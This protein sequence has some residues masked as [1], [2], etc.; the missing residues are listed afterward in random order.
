MNLGSQTADSQLSRETGDVNG[1]GVC[2]SG[3]EALAPVCLGMADTFSLLWFNS[4]IL[5]RGLIF[6]FLT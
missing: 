2:V 6:S 5:L 1:V 4:L 3:C